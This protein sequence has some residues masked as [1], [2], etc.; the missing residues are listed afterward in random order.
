MIRI[1]PI[2]AAMLL[3]WAGDR[4]QAGQCADVALVL[5]IDGSGSINAGDFDLQRMGYYLALTDAPVQAAFDTAGVV[6]IAA[7]FW[8]DAASKPQVIPFHRV[9][10]PEHARAF[11]D[12]LMSTERTVTGNTDIW[13][14]LRAAIDL[15]DGPGTC[16]E[17]LVIDV[18][19]NGRSTVVARRSLESSLPAERQRAHDLG[20]VINALA[21]ADEDP[22]LA[23]YFE[24]RLMTGPTSFVMTVDGFDTFRDAIAKKIMREIL[25]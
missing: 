5:A 17:R 19:G 22:G 25:S 24:R 3:P 13:T 12:E 1:V 8:A 23:E 6:D 10:E 21:I 4:A 16:A 20:I 15:L 2:I 9:T 7:V 14:G 18:S 11:A